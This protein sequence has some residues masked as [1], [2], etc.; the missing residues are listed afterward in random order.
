MILDELWPI[1]ESIIAAIDHGRTTH[2]KTSSN[3]VTRKRQSGAH[4]SQDITF[5]ISAIKN[6]KIMLI[7]Q[8][9]NFVDVATSSFTLVLRLRKASAV[10]LTCICRRSLRNSCRWDGRRICITIRPGIGRYCTGSVSLVFSALSFGK[11]FGIPSKLTYW[12]QRF[13]ASITHVETTLPLSSV[14]ECFSLFKFLFIYLFFCLA[15]IKFH[16]LLVV[17]NF[18][19][20][21]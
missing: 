16:M 17:H 11:W 21:L 20:L 3:H 2:P 12:L 13:I 10:F 15:V 14:S 7:D 8:V 18:F 1:E 6:T 19:K 4:Y 5:S 9:G